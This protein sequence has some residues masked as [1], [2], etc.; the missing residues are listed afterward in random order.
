[1]MINKLPNASKYE[2]SSLSKVALLCLRG[3][4]LAPRVLLR[5]RARKAEAAECHGAPPPRGKSGGGG[6]KGVDQ[7]G[8][9]GICPGGLGEKSKDMSFM[10]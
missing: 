5:L 2:H 6:Q 1:M 8:R 4:L 7:R 3:A 10:N 9:R